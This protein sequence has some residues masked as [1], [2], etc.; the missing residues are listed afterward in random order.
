MIKKIIIMCLMLVTM[1]AGTNAVTYLNSCGKTTGWVNGETY[2]INF[3]EVSVSYLTSGKSGCFNVGN[4]Q[5]AKFTSMNKTVNMKSLKSMFYSYQS[6]PYGF[7]ADQYLFNSTFYDM[8]VSFYDNNQSIFFY[9]FSVRAIF[10]RDSNFR[11]FKVTGMKSFYYFQPGGSA[12]FSYLLDSNMT[13]S[14]LEAEGKLFDVS[15]MISGYSYGGYVR[16]LKIDNSVIEFKSGIGYNNYMTVNFSNSIIMGTDFNSYGTNESELNTIIGYRDS[17]LKNVISVDVND[18]NVA[19]S[20]L[21]PQIFSSRI[22][23]DLFG[24][25][26]IQDFTEGQPFVTVTG[27]KAIVPIKSNDNLGSPLTL[28][29]GS[30]L[31]T[32]YMDSTIFNNYKGL[33]DTSII[34]NNFGNQTLVSPLYN[35]LFGT[36]GFSGGLTTKYRGVIQ[37]NSNNKFSNMYVLQPTSTN[38]TAQ[39]ISNENDVQYDNISI[40]TNAFIDITGNTDMGVDINSAK[41]VIKL[42][43][44]NVNISNNV[45]TYLN[46]GLNQQTFIILESTNPNSNL[47]TKNKFSTGTAYSIPSEIFSYACDTKFYNNYLSS[48]ETVIS[49]TC[50]GINATPLIPYTHTD[51][52]IYYFHVGNYYDGYSDNCSD[53]DGD[54]F[55]DSPYTSGTITDT[56]PLSSYPFDYSA[57]LLSAEY[58]V[59]LSLFNITYYYIANG[60]TYS[61][62]NTFSQL[63]FGFSHDSDFPDLTCD[64]VIDG[65]GITGTTVINP[66]KN[67]IYSVNLS[68]WSEKSYTFRVECYNDYYYKVGQEY[69][70]TVQFTGTAGGGDNNGYVYVDNLTIFDYG[71]ISNTNENSIG[72]MGNILSF[73]I[74]VSIPFAILF[75]IVILFLAGIRLIF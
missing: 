10:I 46:L 47:V 22:S 7:T 33:V 39:F 43:A 20:D 73:I 63:Q 24:Y 48:N 57:H 69:T 42:K 53:V 65:V 36:S 55:C 1:L 44:S 30:P 21:Y 52:K 37:T 74:N 72:F 17:L 70:F 58:V 32:S 64:Y 23:R 12:V 49:N 50:L 27:K 54:G 9:A 18:D 14:W 59:E 15:N 67:Q 61:V 51:G 6:D 11:N 62:D 19:D 16:G 75:V 60:L 25:R 4:L 26:F 5:D 35:C 28:N 68:G 41:P 38:N 56:H 34:C 45:F 13:S 31:D 2:V 3:T 29:F 8:D 40:S 71:S 66:I